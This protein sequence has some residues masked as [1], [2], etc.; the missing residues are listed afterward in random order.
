M[1]AEAVQNVMCLSVRQPWA[2]LIVHGWK[3][4][5]NRT[6]PTKFRGRVLIH[7]SKVMTRG[8]Y[9]ACRLFIASHGMHV[10]IPQ[11]KALARG[12]IVGETTILDCVTHHPSEWF[13]GPFGFVVDGN[14]PLPFVPMNGQLGFFPYRKDGAK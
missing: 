3:N 7:A 1:K 2:W 6:W 11:F 5:E 8:D 14:K 10:E 12:G 4:V 9:D 13:T